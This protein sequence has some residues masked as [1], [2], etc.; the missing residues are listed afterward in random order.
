VTPLL[1]ASTTGLELADPAGSLL[2]V[3]FVG[4]GGGYALVALVD[5][6]RTETPGVGEGLFRFMD[7][8]APRGPRTWVIEREGG[9]VALQPLSSHRTH[10]VWVHGRLTQ[11][12]ERAAYLGA[13]RRLAAGFPDQQAD[14]QAWSADYAARPIVDP[15]AR[16]RA[17][18]A[19]PR[20]VGVLPLLDQDGLAVDVLALD[21]RGNAASAQGDAWLDSL[22]SQWTY[23]DADGAVRPALSE[24]LGWAS[25]Q[26]PLGRTYPG[27]P[28]VVTAEGS[29]KRIARQVLAGIL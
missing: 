12:I 2:A 28:R 16:L 6:W 20:P 19:V 7:T 1:D 8:P 17:A 21:D 13:L 25:S 9:H 5:W 4:V 23:Y 26:R 15:G 27:T 29:T 24:F 3:D 10:D 18:N 11:D 22:A 14:I